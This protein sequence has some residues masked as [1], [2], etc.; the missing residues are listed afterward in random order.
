MASLCQLS[1]ASQSA[2]A[3]RKRPASRPRPSRSLQTLSRSDGSSL[4]LSSTSPA[5]SLRLIWAS[6]TSTA[7]RRRAK[8]PRARSANVGTSCLI[9]AAKSTLLSSKTCMEWRKETKPRSAWSSARAASAARKA[10]SSMSP[11][12]TTPSVSGLTR[13]PVFQP[14]SALLMAS[15]LAAN[16]AASSGDAPA[17]LFASCFATQRRSS[18]SKQSI[19]QPKSLLRYSGLTVTRLKAPTTT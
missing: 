9:C 17:I 6:S 12:R 16:D 8:T 1:K 15:P 11:G 2:F 3:S 18:P 10:P 14:R 13:T 4:W 19:C 7:S 5:A